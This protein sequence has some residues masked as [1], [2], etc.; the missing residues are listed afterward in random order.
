VTKIPT[1]SLAATA[2]ITTLALVTDCAPPPPAPPPFPALTQNCTATDKP[3]IVVPPGKGVRI[4][5]GRRGNEPSLVSVGV[6][7]DDKIKEDGRIYPSGPDVSLY[8]YRFN[9]PMY[10]TPTDPPRRVT[11]SMVWSA[12]GALYDQPAVYTT[13]CL[14]VNGATINF[15]ATRHPEP[16]TIVDFEFYPERNLQVRKLRRKVPEETVPKVPEEPVPKVE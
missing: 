5:V 9:N 4:L 3:D 16:N 10:F 15:Y 12:N 1:Q 11:A 14:L 2:L 13:V 7:I 6:R 8:P